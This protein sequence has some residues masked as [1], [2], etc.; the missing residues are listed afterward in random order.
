MSPCDQVN[1]SRNHR[2]SVNERT[3]GSRASHR[4]W[5]PGL[6]RELRG[7][8]DGAT[9][10]KGR[11]RDRHAGPPSPLR[12]CTLQ[13]RLNLQRAEAREKHEQADGHRGVADA[14][15]K[16]CLARGTSVNGVFVPEADQKIAA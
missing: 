16:E 9:E 5:K 13:E 1:P 14:R 7:F 12:G 8:S 3:D 15:D 2:G 6:K 4:I 10:K 11:G